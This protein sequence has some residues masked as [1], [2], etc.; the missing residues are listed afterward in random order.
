[1]TNEEES[2]YLK[3]VLYGT[4]RTCDN[5][6]FIDCENFQRQRRTVPCERHKTFQERITELEK[7][8]KE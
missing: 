2:K 4:K 7:N 1:M 6:G 5:C 3:A 8:Y